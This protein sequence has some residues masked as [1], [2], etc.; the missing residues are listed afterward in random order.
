M[1]FRSAIGALSNLAI[2]TQEDAP[3]RHKIGNIAIMGGETKAVMNE[4]NI[5]CDPEAADKVLAS[6][7]PLFMGT[8]IQTQR[9]FLTMEEVEEHYSAGKHPAHVALRDCTRLWGPH[10]GGKVG[11]VLYDLVPIF[12]TA[13]PTCVKTEKSHVRV[14]MNGTYTR[15]QTVRVRREGE[16]LITESVDLDPQELVNEF[17]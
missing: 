3:A 16:P 4:Y 13:Y 11:P 10:R 6:G 9:L 8:F 5:W 2:A 12:Y 7:I 14:E 1:L 15:G 17:L